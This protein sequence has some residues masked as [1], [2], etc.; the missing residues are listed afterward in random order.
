[1]HFCPSASRESFDAVR[2]LV[3]RGP[4]IIVVSFVSGLCGHLASTRF[5]RSA[6]A[7]ALLRVAAVYTVG[8]VELPDEVAARVNSLGFR[9]TLLNAH[10]QPS[11]QDSSIT[12][13]ATLIEATRFVR[14]TATS[15][16]PQTAHT[17]ILMAAEKL[18][19]DHDRR[20]EELQHFFETRIS[21]L[22]EEIF[23]LEEQLS[24]EPPEGL[25][26]SASA[27]LMAE[28]T[29][30]E[31]RL[32]KLRLRRLDLA[33]G[34]DAMLILRTDLVDPPAV[35]VVSSGA[36]LILGA[37]FAGMFAATAI[38]C[39]QEL[40]RRCAHEEAESHATLGL[41]DTEL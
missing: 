12:L 41:D 38:S 17:I 39:A 40:S 3:R 31:A 23:A 6:R 36:G 21:L 37:M 22:D 2:F 8:F 32:V 16:D 34:T 18:K 5:F 10:P 19:V 28:H 1:M 30:S 26:V 9:N 29:R 13:T 24:Q 7:E 4:L 27:H 35:R 15:R 20:F 14:L 33:P 11:A 25:S